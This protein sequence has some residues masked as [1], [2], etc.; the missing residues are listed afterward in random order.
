MTRTN[1]P[2]LGLAL[3]I[4]IAF[5]TLLP[6]FATY[7][8][9]AIPSPL[10]GDKILICTGDGFALVNRSDLL[11]GKAPVKPHPDYACALCY[12]AASP[13][14]KLLLLAVALDF[15]VRQT[16]ERVSLA[17]AAVRAKPPARAL[18]CPRAPPLSFCR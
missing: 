10:F 16:S 5:A 18:P 11:A 4:A 15:F 7:S 9:S 6:F 14:G 8:H 1:H 17:F 12:L 13:L 3:A 2:W